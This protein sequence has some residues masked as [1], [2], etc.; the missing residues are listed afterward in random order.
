MKK[1]LCLVAGTILAASVGSAAEPAQQAETPPMTFFVTSVGSGNG[2][3][4]GGLEGADKHCQQ[5]AEAVGSAGQVWRAYLSTDREPIVHARDRI[6]TGPWHNAKGQIIAQNLAELHGDTIELA[7]ADNRINRVTAIT[8]KGTP[9]GS[10]GEAPPLQHDILTGSQTDGR[11]YSDGADH[12]CKNW[13]SSSDGSAQVGHHDRT[14]PRS[15]SW[16]SAHP[17]RGC[18]QADLEATGGAGMF[19]CFATR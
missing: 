9:I 6:G 14:S 4:L 2:A 7:R 15:N 16:N 8:E 19:Y 11:A 5:L 10:V 18:G 3:N 1:T 13:T 12:T 17:S